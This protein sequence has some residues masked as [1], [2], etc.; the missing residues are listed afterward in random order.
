MLLKDVKIGQIV[1]CGT[2]TLD[3]REYKQE[4]K[5]EE[6]GSF[7]QERQQVA[8]AY[9]R[10]SNGPNAGYAKWFKANELEPK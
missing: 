10:I 5:V 2:F 6:I 7:R 1:F 9:C 4:A 3:Q 8:G